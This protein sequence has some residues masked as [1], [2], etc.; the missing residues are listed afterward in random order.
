MPDHASRTPKSSPEG[1]QGT[2]ATNP[3]PTRHLAPP[4]KPDA[5]GETDRRH[6][7]DGAALREALG[8][9]GALL[10]AGLSVALLARRRGQFRRRRSGRTITPTQRE[11][12]TAERAVRT[13]GAGGGESAAFL[14]LALRD[15]AARA[16]HEGFELPEIVAARLA[17]DSLELITQH[18]APLAPR[19]WRQRDDG[20]GWVLSRKVVIEP[21]ESLAP[22]P[23]LVAVGLD[24]ESA[25]WLID[26]EAAGIVHLAGDRERCRQLARYMAAELATNNWSDDIDVIVAGLGDEVIDINPTR[27]QAADALDVNELTKA[28]RRIHEATDATGLGVLAGRVEATGGDTWMPT[29]MIADLH[30]SGDAA[31]PR[32]AE[33]GDELSLGTGRGAIAL[34]HIGTSPAPGARTVTVDDSGRM[35]N[36]W[37]PEL[38]SNALSGVEARLLSELVTDRDQDADHLCGDI[39]EPM[40]AATGTGSHDELADAAGALRPVF[41]RTR[42]TAS[43][44]HSLL[45]EADATYLEAAA[46]TAEDLQALAPSVPEDTRVRAL[47]ADPTLDADL[48]EWAAPEVH[49]P[50]L[51]V[52]GP[53]EASVRG[54]RPYDI[55]RRLA[56]Y[57]EMLAYLATKPHGATPHQM[58]SDFQI[59]TNT[60]HSRIGTLRKWL[61][62][63]E[64]TDTW[65]LP[66]STLSEA[67]RARGVPVYELNGVLTD[68]DLFR[69]LRVRAQ[70]LGHDGIRDL[71]TGLELVR[72]MPFDQQRVGGYG[73]LAET[74]HD[75][76]LT[77]GIVDV[78]H[79]VAT[80]ALANG[81]PQLAAWAA[82]VG[83]LA[84]PSEDKPR[85]DLARATSQLGGDESARRYVRDQVLNR[86]DDRQ[87]PAEPTARTTAVLGQLEL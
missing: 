80:H 27:L 37:S 31:D 53:I 81:D 12:V 84:A 74:P 5:T 83:I 50:R 58:A 32:I 8:G 62:Q 63:H 2:D 44:T 20:A 73:W 79:V 65:H 85:L 41:T 33:L 13:L 6:D 3:A 14:D 60:L 76:H 77:A 54:D 35:H 57:T 18:P 38:K 7:D 23:T 75:H 39:D 9:A 46:T 25:T 52:L 64:A 82:E 78:A 71:I 61:G 42:T 55:E 29:I 17:E 43:D 69:R 45:A 1:R 51:R 22:Y 40:P 72:G 59:Q 19:P 47:A 86:S 21:T 4:D 30:D 56:Y 36:P 49:R 87:P 11:L 24:T 16:Q 66:E 67:A 10:A 48:T 70:A 34:V 15:L 28:V 68:S 26:L